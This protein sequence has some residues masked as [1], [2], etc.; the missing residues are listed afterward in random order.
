MRAG[1]TWYEILG[2]LPG[3]TTAE[4]RRGYDLKAGLLKPQYLSG[5]TSTVITAARRAQDILD[6]AWLELGDPARRAEYDQIAGIRRFGGGLER[7]ESIPTESGWHGSEYAYLP[8]RAAAFLG[9]LMAAADW[10]APQPRQPGRVT[11]PDVRGLFYSVCSGTVGRMGLRVTAVRLTEHPM[12]VDGLI[13]DQSPRPLEKARRGSELT[14]RVWHPAK[15][16]T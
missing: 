3:A 16:S 7:P 6:Q 12:P 10:L 2:V 5:A 14:L 4:I 9:A 13:V 8:M 11:V 15:V 1:I